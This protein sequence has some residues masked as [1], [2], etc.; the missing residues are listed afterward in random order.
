M[1]VEGR[2]AFSS[3]PQN[4]WSHRG[5]Y[6]PSAARG[7]GYSSNGGHF[8]DSSQDGSRFDAS[9]FDIGRTEVLSTDLQQRVVMENVYEALENAGFTI[10]DVRGSK[11]SVF[12]GAAN[13]GIHLDPDVLLEHKHAGSSN[14][15]IANRVSWFYDLRGCSMTLDTACSSSL[16]ALHLA[17]NDLRQEQSTMVCITLQTSQT[18][19]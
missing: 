7:G 10:E 3:V 19:Y 15:I 12:A 18:C 2:S 6:H 9:F 17:C 11:T 13:N 4:K 14:S 1:L 8:L 5:H 16:V